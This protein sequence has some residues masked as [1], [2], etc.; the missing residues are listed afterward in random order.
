M[1]VK[2]LKEYQASVGKKPG[3]TSEEIYI[4]EFDGGTKAVF[5]PEMYLWSSIG[6]LGAYRYSRWLGLDIVPPTVIREIGGKVGSLQLYVESDY[7]NDKYGWGDRYKMYQGLSEEEKIKLSLFHFLIGQWDRHVEN[8]LIA[9]NGCVFAIDNECAMNQIRVSYG[10]YPFVMNGVFNSAYVDSNE[11]AEFPFSQVRIVENPTVEKLEAA[12][13][14]GFFKPGKRSKKIENLLEKSRKNHDSSIQIVIWRGYV[15]IKEDTKS[16]GPAFSKSIP[17]DLEIK[18]RSLTR[19]T[20]R[21]ILPDGFNDEQVEE[22]WRRR[23]QLL[24]FHQ[25]GSN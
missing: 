6:E 18:L 9:R 24:D 4:V 19:E 3:G 2:N 15:W 17:K 1:S 13:P 23:N 25:D 7:F 20:L 16:L 11:P 21:A 5:K 12:I 10:D 14:E 22:F 8:I